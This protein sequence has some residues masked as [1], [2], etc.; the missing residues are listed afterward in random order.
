MWCSDN[1]C[2]QNTYTHKIIK[3]KEIKSLN[4]ISV[5]VG[6]CLIFKTYVTQPIG[7]SLKCLGDRT[8]RPSLGSFHTPWTLADA[9]GWHSSWQV[10]DRQMASWRQNGW[11]RSICCSMSHFHPLAI[12]IAV[13]SRLEGCHLAKCYFPNNSLLNICCAPGHDGKFWACNESSVLSSD[14]VE[15][16]QVSHLI[17][18]D[19][20]WKKEAH[21]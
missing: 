6:Q 16:T 13:G 21:S 1:P 19:F 14:F 7:I 12:E 11:G 17:L 4:S 8:L 20:T 10:T 15:V 9:L 3:S 2:R 18:L 5:R